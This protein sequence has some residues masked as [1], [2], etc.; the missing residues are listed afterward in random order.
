M[1]QM[2]RDRREQYQNSFVQSLLSAKSFQLLCY[3]SLMYDAQEGYQDIPESPAI[4]ILSLPIIFPFSVNGLLLGIC[5]LGMTSCELP[6]PSM[7]SGEG[8]PSS[9]LDNIAWL[10]PSSVKKSISEFRRERL[11][12]DM[13]PSTGDSRK[14]GVTGSEGVAFGERRLASDGETFRLAPGDDFIEGEYEL[15]ISS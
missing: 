1:E 13:E 6:L 5:M 2:P 15:A 7:T 8:N 4:K 14:Q 10:V 11:L 12:A 3:V 9:P